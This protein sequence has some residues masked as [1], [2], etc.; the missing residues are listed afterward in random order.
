MQKAGHDS[1]R[2]EFGVARL[3][4]RGRRRRGG[5]TYAL[6]AL[7][8]DAT[9]LLGHHVVCQLPDLLDRN[10]DLGVGGLHGLA[11]E[12]AGDLQVVRVGDLAG[13]DEPGTQG[14]ERVK[15]LAVGPL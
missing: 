7:I 13:R 2:S 15:A 1:A 3:E 8:G 9:L 11:V 14:T 5:I 6:R 10:S 4:L 12:D